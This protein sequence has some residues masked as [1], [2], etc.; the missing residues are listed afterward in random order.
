MNTVEKTLWAR[1]NRRASKLTP[2]LERAILKALADLRASI[3][4]REIISLIE[5]G[6]FDQIIDDAQLKASF[7]QV[8]EQLQAATAQAVKLAAMDLPKSVS[9]G[10]DMLNPDIVTA[11]RQLDTKVVQSLADDVRETVRAFVE[12]GLRDGVSPKEIARDL[13]DVIGLSPKQLEQVQNY[14][15]ALEGK[16]GRLITNYTLRD[17]RFS[18]A[19]LT[20]ERIDKMVSLYEKRRIAQNAETVSRTTALDSM[21]LGQQLSIDSAVDQGIYDPARLWKRWVGVMDDREREEHVAMEGEEVPYDE[22]YSNAEDVPG[23]STYNCRCISRFFQK[24]AA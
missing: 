4:D 10:F 19:N 11:I 24:T 16:N 14:R 17:K 20:P 8:S 7:A 12:N 6:R 18:G 15:D 3:T 1:L 2:A 13:R 23:E 21:K 22:P 9:V 5:Q